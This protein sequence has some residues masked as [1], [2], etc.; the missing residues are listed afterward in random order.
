VN[1]LASIVERKRVEVEQRKAETPLAALEERVSG[2][3]PSRSLYAAMG[4]S[5]GE[6]RVVAEIKR[7]SP[8]RGTIKSELDSAEQARLYAGS[9]ASGISVLTD[10]EGFGGSL[11]DLV[12]V[13]QAV[14][15]PVLRKDFI[16]DPY[17]LVEAR[18][19]GADAI[20]LIVGALDED[21]LTN[22]HAIAYELNLEALVEV[23][24]ESELD[25][26][27]SLLGCSLIGI[28]NRDLATFDI[29]LGVSERLAPEVAPPIRVISESGISSADDIRRLRESGITNFLVGEA[30][31]ASNDAGGLL[32]QLRGAPV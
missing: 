25:R 6:T 31:V 23:H 28:N 17:Q 11:D 4:D 19:S 13:R 2:S 9:G 5:G 24:D 21:R 26:A 7:A 14:E 15:L 32:R 10:G 29:D 18:A 1:I 16:I 20:L 27:R 22:L 3:A 12:A 30:L 8:S